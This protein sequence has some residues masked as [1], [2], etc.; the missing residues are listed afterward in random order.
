MIAE[1]TIRT[2]EF[3]KVLDLLAAQT[4]FSLS[5]ELALALRPSI[6]AEEVR[7]LQAQTR[8]GL[9]LLEARVDAS[10]GGAHDIRPSVQR[11]ALGGVARSDEPPGHAEHPGVRRPDPDR[12]GPPVS[13]RSTRG[14]W[15]YAPVSAPSGTRSR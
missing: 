8:E 9:R 10:L 14:W 3:D 7:E 2:L 13:P 1:K 12:P 5:K 6:D 15:G 11:A 4:S